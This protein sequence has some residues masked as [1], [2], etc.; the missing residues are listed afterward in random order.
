MFRNMTNQRILA[1]PSERLYNYKISKDQVIL[2]YNV[3]KSKDISLRECK[4][5]NV[6]RPKIG[7]YLP[8]I[9]DDD[10][11]VTSLI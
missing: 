5:L 7:I 4:D 1:K 11:I 2:F 3:A 9:R 6:F 10:A 8:F